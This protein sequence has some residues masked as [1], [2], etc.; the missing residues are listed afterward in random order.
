MRNINSRQDLREYFS[1][2]LDWGWGYQ[3]RLVFD[4]L[5]RA[6][7]FCE[8]DAI[9]DAGAGRQRYR[10]FFKTCFYITQE[11]SAGIK[12]KGMENVPYDLI[13]PIDEKIPLRDSSLA[14]VLST[15][16]LEHIAEP[17][18]FIYEAF[19]VLRPG[20]KL[21][22]NCPFCYQE[23]EAPYDF[24]RP[25]RYALERWLSRAGF[26]DVEVSPSS[27]STENVTSFLA[28]AV[29]NDIRRTSRPFSDVYREV[30]QSRSGYFKLLGFALRF[31]FAKIVYTLLQWLGQLLRWAVDRGPHEGTTFPLGWIV[32]AK[33]PG[34]FIK[35]DVQSEGE[36][37]KRFGVGAPVQP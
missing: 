6:A 26:T 37:L 17:Q 19:R 36:F 11:H 24:T 29:W 5:L 16:V 18:Q 14:G 34:Q 31:G 15:S 32:V 13:S 27:S 9:L 7:E 23:H 1:R 12:F 8:H 3:A 2:D 30:K 22:L 20:G 28:G 10:P 21:F 4:L 35:G 33:K 25:T